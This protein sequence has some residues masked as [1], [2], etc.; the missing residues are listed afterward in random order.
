[1]VAKEGAYITGSVTGE[2][3][4]PA[5]GAMVGWVQ[6]LDGDGNVMPD[7][8]Y[9]N[10]STRADDRGQFRLGPLETGRYRVMALVNP[11]ALGRADAEA[12]EKPIEIEL[13]P[14]R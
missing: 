12:G 14:D 6:T 8:T 9:V 3:G 2:D 1:M 11:R 13:K 4:K 7:R 10:R 5:R